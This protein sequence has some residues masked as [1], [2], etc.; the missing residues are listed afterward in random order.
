MVNNMY[1]WRTAIALG[2]ISVAVVLGE[3]D[4]APATFTNYGIFYNII[5]F[6]FPPLIPFITLVKLITKLSEPIRGIL[7][8]L[9]N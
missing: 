8:Y 3:D 7:Y 6:L 2:L 1:Y 5:G 4:V 9:I